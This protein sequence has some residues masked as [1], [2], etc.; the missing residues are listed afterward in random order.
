PNQMP[1]PNQGQTQGGFTLPPTTQPSFASTFPQNFNPIDYQLSL[2]MQSAPLHNLIP[3]KLKDKI[4][5]DEYIALSSLVKGP[6]EDKNND[7]V[8]CEMKSDGSFES[9]HLNLNPSKKGKILSFPEWIR[10]FSIFIAVYTQRFPDQ[11][12]H[13]LKYMVS[14]TELFQRHQGWRVYDEK[15]RDERAKTK[16]PWGM[17]H[18]EY[19]L[20]AKELN[21]NASTLWISKH[22]QNMFGFTDNKMYYPPKNSQKTTQSK[23]EIPLGY[24]FPFHQGLTCD[25]SPCPFNHTCPT[26]NRSKHSM[27]K[28]YSRN[29]NRQ[30]QFPNKKRSSTGDSKKPFE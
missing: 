24:C 23:S 11:T 2:S 8:L 17:L 19:W 16:F 6:E 7:Y 18:F 14:V 13:L 21:A 12:P 25:K 27:S 29:N 4:W 10:A 20:K 28:C 3:Q 9:K 15:F 26:C 22:E 1:F 5:A 30:A